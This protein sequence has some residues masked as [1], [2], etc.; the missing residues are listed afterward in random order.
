MIYL[1][2][3]LFKAKFN[4]VYFFSIFSNTTWCYLNG[5]VEHQMKHTNNKLKTIHTHM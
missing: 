5:V 3:N 2:A 4:N 1:K